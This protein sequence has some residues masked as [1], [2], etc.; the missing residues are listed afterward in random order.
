MG[1]F[2]SI[3]LD[4]LCPVCKEITSMECQTKE[5]DCD[6]LVYRKGDYIGTNKY[7]YLE[8]HA[9]CLSPACREFEKQKYQGRV[10]GFGRSVYVKVFLKDG[11]ITGEHEIIN[12]ESE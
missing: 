1:M 5:L 12:Y 11:I 3:Y 8:T 7:N 2:D 10:I 9:S 4:I 6:L